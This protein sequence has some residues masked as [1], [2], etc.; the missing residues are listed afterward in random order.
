MNLKRAAW[1]GIIVY[2]VSFA[3]GILIAMS[4]G[5]DMNDAANTPDMLWY[6]AMI[7]TIIVLALFSLWYFKDKKT[8]PSPKEGF[9][10]GLTFVVMGF[11]LDMIILAIFSVVSD[12]PTDMMSYYANSL[13][14][15]TIV[16]LVAT[17]TIIGWY[18]GKN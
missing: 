18:K 16:I 8:K 1:M 14:W 7:P 3:I 5:L 11:I 9:Y 13:F 2:I 6:I 15:L 10:L 12:M 17:T 4:M